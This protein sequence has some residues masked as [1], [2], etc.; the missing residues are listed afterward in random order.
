MIDNDKLDLILASSSQSRKN[1]LNGAG[2]DFTAKSPDVDEAIIKQHN[3]KLGVLP[4]QTAQDLADAKALIVS[5]QNRACLTLGS[6]QICHLHGE[7]F[8]KP[9]NK[10][11][12][13]KHLRT[14]SGKTHTLTSAMSMAL[15]GKI[16]FRYKDHAQLTMYK[17]S[18]D[19]IRHYIECASDDVVNAAGG[20]HLEDVGVQLFKRIEGSYFTVL[21]LPLLPLIEFLNQWQADEAG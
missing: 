2:I 17:L 14:L 8:D 11:G 13:F 1:L 15:D 10:D 20:Y 6:D 7:I 5:Q 18:D 4:Q 9:G 3:L 19:D 12:L 16:I 21:G